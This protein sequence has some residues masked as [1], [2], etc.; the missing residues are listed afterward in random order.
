MGLDRELM[1]GLRVLQA[2]LLGPESAWSELCDIDLEVHESDVGQVLDMFAD[3]CIESHCNSNTLVFGYVAGFLFA[4]QRYSLMS[5]EGV[6]NTQERALSD[7]LDLAR[8]LVSQLEL[9]GVVFECWV[10]WG[11][12]SLNKSDSDKVTAND[13]Q[14]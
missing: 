4:R 6:S 10:P 9:R 13:L 1:D 8:V 5:V 2:S 12:P 11:W 14:S 7:S 3:L